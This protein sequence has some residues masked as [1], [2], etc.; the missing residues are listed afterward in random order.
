MFTIIK[1]VSLRRTKE[2]TIDGKPL[3][4]LPARR[5]H[6]THVEFS[7]D[8]RNFYDYLREKA[9][10]KFSKYLNSGTVMKHYS[11][12]RQLSSFRIKVMLPYS[13]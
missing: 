8:E 10:A 3:L 12:V 11:S 13:P 1:A 9:Q 2:G 6:I 7:E 5:V 4:V